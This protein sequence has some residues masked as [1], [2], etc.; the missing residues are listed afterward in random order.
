MQAKLIKAV[1]S[2]AN[3][4]VFMKYYCNLEDANF[5]RNDK[6]KYRVFIKIV[7]CDTHYAFLYSLAFNI[8]SDYSV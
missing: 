2:V 5:W 7:Y 6:L 8:K 3:V 1:S 4:F